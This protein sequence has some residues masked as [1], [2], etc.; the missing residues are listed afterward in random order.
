MAIAYCIAAGLS[1]TLEDFESYLFNHR[2]LNPTTIH[3]YLGVI[4]RVAPAIGLRPS[5][6]DVE[7]YVGNMRREERSYSHQIN[8][9]VALENYMAYLGRKV[10][11]ARPRKPKRILREVLSEP[12]VTLII[13]AARTVRER[14][15]LS[16]LAY[17]GLRNAELCHLRI[18]DIDIAHQTVQVRGGKGAK[19]RTV[20]IGGGC[21]ETLMSYLGERNGTTEDLLFRTVRFEHP[22]QTQDLRKLVRVVACRA[23]IRKRVHPHLLRHSL[24]TAMINRGAHLLSVRDQ[25]GHEYVETT[26]IYV[27]TAQTRLQAE[28]R[29]YCPTYM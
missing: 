25:L 15:I 19:D 9:A 20:C 28:Y 4:R 27:H 16:L 26:M 24:A 2:A 8:T 10:R 14:A 6:R 22:Y 7:R 11:L 29:M 3:N 12:E 17:S 13:A 1:E 21:I 5:P 23:G 18:G